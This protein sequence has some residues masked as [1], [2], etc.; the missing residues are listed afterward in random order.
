[1]SVTIQWIRVWVFLLLVGVNIICATVR[2][3]LDLHVGLLKDL[4]SGCLVLRDFEDH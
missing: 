2:T 1:M 3:L 4:V